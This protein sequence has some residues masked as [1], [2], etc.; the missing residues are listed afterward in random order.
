MQTVRLSSSN[1][2]LDAPE[3][4]AT[5]EGKFRE[6]NMKLLRISH[7]CVIVHDSAIIFALVVTYSNFQHHASKRAVR[8]RR[9]FNH[10]TCVF[11]LP[12]LPARPKSPPV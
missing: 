11:R 9:P 3:V 4:N 6:E 2:T 12:G 7:F 8:R 1:L 5:F 10:S